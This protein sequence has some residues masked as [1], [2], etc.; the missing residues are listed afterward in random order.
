MVSASADAARAL[1]QAK[2]KIAAR[3]DHNVDEAFRALL[4]TPIGRDFLWWLLRIGKWGSQPYSSDALQMAFNC[5]EMNCG[6][7]VLARIL[8]VNSEGF[9]TMQ[10]ERLNDVRNIAAAAGSAD[11]G[12]EAGDEPIDA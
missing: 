12:S 6:Q 7:Q 9:V 10:E 8:D 3:E 2:L 11:D 1:E 5:G 4:G